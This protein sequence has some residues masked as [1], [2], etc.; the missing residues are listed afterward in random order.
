M[1]GGPRAPCVPRVSIGAGLCL[2]MVEGE[3]GGEEEEALPAHLVDAPRWGWAPGARGAELGPLAGSHAEA[4][5][6]CTSAIFGEAHG[7]QFSALG[8]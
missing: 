4:A 1:E 8:V 5:T 6:R 2:P 7:R 3:G